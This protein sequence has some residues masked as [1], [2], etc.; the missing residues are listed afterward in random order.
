MFT[1][2]L[3]ALPL[4]VYSWGPQAPLL[5]LTCLLLI[6]SV[7]APITAECILLI[8]LRVNLL[9]DRAD[10]LSLLL[11][12]FGFLLPTGFS[13]DSFTW[14]LVPFIAWLLLTF[15]FS[16]LACVFIP[17]N[18][19]FWA[20]VLLPGQTNCQFPNMSNNLIP[21]YMLFFLPT[22]LSLSCHWVVGSCSPF[23]TQFSYHFLWSFSNPIATPR[24]TV[25]SFL[26]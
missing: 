19:F 18:A 3:S 26:P 4:A 12:F 8:L 6:I 13:P 1:F 2:D 22:C 5:F 20:S 7:P 11:E 17:I 15:P 23:K 9:E 14:C 24:R 21:S 25:P 16:V 10:L